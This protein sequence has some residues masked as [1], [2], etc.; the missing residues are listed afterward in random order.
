MPGHP[1]HPWGPAGHDS[2]PGNTPVTQS[3]TCPAC[4]HLPMAA[5]LVAPSGSYCLRQ[6]CVAP[7]ELGDSVIMPPSHNVTYSPLQSS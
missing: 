3:S 7:W 6:S 1:G 4:T 2:L 5:H